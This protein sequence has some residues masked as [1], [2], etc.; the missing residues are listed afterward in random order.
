MFWRQ[1]CLILLVSPEHSI[2]V[3]QLLL[4]GQQV[5]GPETLV[6]PIVGKPFASYP[7]AAQITADLRRRF[8]TNV[9]GVLFA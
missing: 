3:W 1:K 6:D 4:Y 2:W 8:L 7:Q 5:H 9:Q